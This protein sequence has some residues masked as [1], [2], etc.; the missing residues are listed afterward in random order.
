[1]WLVHIHTQA[2]SQHYSPQAALLSLWSTSKEAKS[3]GSGLRQLRRKVTLRE[4]AV[5]IAQLRNRMTGKLYIVQGH[6]LCVMVQ[7]HAAP[8]QLLEAPM[9]A[10]E[11]RS[12]AGI[13][14][15]VQQ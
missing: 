15:Q 5:V 14:C 7:E 1:M 10:L 11:R 13:V 6:V 12:N 2:A 3:Q 9:H 8:V 4:A